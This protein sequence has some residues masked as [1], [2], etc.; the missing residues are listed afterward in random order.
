MIVT[1]YSSSQLI[2]RSL[3]PWSKTNLPFERDKVSLGSKPPPPS[4]MRHPQYRT[5]RVNFFLNQKIYQNY[6]I[7]CP[8]STLNCLFGCFKSQNWF[9]SP[10]YCLNPWLHTF[11]RLP[12]HYHVIKS[13]AVTN[14]NKIP[15]KLLP[16]CWHKAKENR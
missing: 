16:I 12:L 1:T 3:G 10:L 8:E 4:Q 13:N 11:L 14:V 6:P 2:H 9:V 5:F 7:F 15:T